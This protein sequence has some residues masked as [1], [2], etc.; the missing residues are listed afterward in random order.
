M[1]LR[2]KTTIAS[3]M[4]KNRPRVTLLL[5]MWRASGIR[6][7]S[8]SAATTTSITMNRV[9]CNSPSPGIG[10]RGR[11]ISWPTNGTSSVAWSSTCDS[12]S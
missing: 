6:I 5:A 10:I 8:I 11:W 4:L 2:M 1:P 3:K 9:I 12:G 7:R